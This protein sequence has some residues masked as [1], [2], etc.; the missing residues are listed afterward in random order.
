MALTNGWMW[1]RHRLEK[2]KL[3]ARLHGLVFATYRSGSTA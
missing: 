1:W 2:L 3:A